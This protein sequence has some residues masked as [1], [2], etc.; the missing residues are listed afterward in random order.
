MSSKDFIHAVRVVDGQALTVYGDPGDPESP[1]VVSLGI[2]DERVSLTPEMA[3]ELC[4]DIQ[5]A[6][7]TATGQAARPGGP[8]LP[9]T[10]EHPKE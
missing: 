2:N 8:W 5:L 6:I 10:I 4:D 1:P 3:Q 9:I 7:R